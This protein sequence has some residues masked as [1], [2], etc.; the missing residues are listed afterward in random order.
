[1]D[2]I[3][4]NILKP[5]EV[6][7]TRRV[8]AATSS[9]AFAVYDRIRFHRRA[10]S[11][12][13]GLLE[14]LKHHMK[15]IAET[16]GGE[17]SAE[18]R[19]RTDGLF[20]DA[21]AETVER[22]AHSRTNSQRPMDTSE[23]QKVLE[24]FDRRSDL[25]KAW[26]TVVQALQKQAG[27]AWQRYARDSVDLAVAAVPKIQDFSY[28]TG[29]EAK[30]KTP[31]G[32]S[33]SSFSTMSVH[34]VL[35]DPTALQKAEDATVASAIVLAGLAILTP[36]TWPIVLAAPAI[37]LL[38]GMMSGRESRSSCSV[39]AGELPE[40]IGR[41]AGEKREYLRDKLEEK[42]IEA[43]EASRDQRADEI[44][45]AAACKVLGSVSV[46]KAEDILR[47]LEGIVGQCYALACKGQD[48]KAVAAIDRWERPLVI[49]SGPAGDVVLDALLNHVQGRLDL[50]V[51][52][53]AFSFSPL[54]KRLRPGVSTRVAVIARRGDRAEVEGGLRQELRH[55]RGEIETRFV[56]A[57]SDM[58]EPGWRWLLITED[59]AL[60]S[61]VSL[62]RLGRQEVVM[63][64]FPTGRLGAEQVFAAYWEGRHTKYGQMVS[65]RI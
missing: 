20:H 24:D 35:G 30:H 52:G 42:I 48:G 32:V 21:V 4:R 3:R 57:P 50:L 5:A 37:G 39:N 60:V 9:T 33:P 43:I 27:D 1:M 31:S 19:R 63:D 12:Q 44:L 2:S 26:E 36:L 16:V 28:S 61:R 11:D 41:A 49:R 7:R 34:E 22:F 18:I 23:I 40:L 46:S 51:A 56:E 47:S 6:D 13:I 10:L 8:Q 65:R 55:W 15:D 38:T 64:D 29:V 59:S 14:H 53:G 54:L 62:N 45:R 17:L 25:R 58:P